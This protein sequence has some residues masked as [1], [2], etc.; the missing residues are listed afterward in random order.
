[1][2][3]EILLVSLD[4]DSAIDTAK[5]YVG[6]WGALRRCLVA[7]LWQSAG[8]C[9]SYDVRIFFGGGVYAVCS[10]FAENIPRGRAA[11]TDGAVL[12]ALAR[13]GEGVIFAP[14]PLGRGFPDAVASATAGGVGCAH[15]PE[16][17]PLG[18]RTL[19]GNGYASDSLTVVDVGPM[20]GAP[21]RPEGCAFLPGSADRVPHVLDRAG[22]ALF[23]CGG[24]PQ[25]KSWGEARWRRSLSRRKA[26]SR[27]FRGG[28]L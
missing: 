25:G 18:G 22:N 10:D 27:F 24:V 7:W 5:P 17:D 6:R 16:G 11:P 1:M 14:Y 28:L 12:R 15:A 21:L 9:V 20:G 19:C 3:R 4:T 2:R 23:F 8:V 26:R 13:L